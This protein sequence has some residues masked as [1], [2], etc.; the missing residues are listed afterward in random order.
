MSVD[1][2]SVSAV[3]GGVIIG[4]Q[5]VDLASHHTADS[6]AAVFTANGQAFTAVS[7]SDSGVAI[8]GGTTLSVGGQAVTV[9]GATIS[10]VS[11]GVVV[12]GSTIGYENA[13][14]TASPAVL[15]LGSN[16]ATAS[17]IGSDVFAIGT[18]TLTAGGSDATISG[19]IVSAATTGI[20]VDGSSSSKEASKTQS[21][22]A[23]QTTSTD[24]ND[25]PT[26]AGSEASKFDA[27]HWAALVGCGFLLL[28]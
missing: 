16:I 3:D 22:Q 18:V 20:V 25:Q 14:P 26:A 13:S 12:D 27:I 15:T 8:I 21:S 28:L 17:A 11:N 9:Q 10:A 7:G 24:Q 2:Q 19:Y 6:R 23:T 1:G 4:T 5:T